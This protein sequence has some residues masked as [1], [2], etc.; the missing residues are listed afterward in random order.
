MNETGPLS[1]TS[2]AAHAR[3][4]RWGV[5]AAATLAQ[6]STCFLVQGF[7]P[8][9]PFMQDALRL[10]AFQIGLLTS[11]AQ[12]VPVIG[13]LV[14]G[15]LLDRFSERLIVGGGAL[16]VAI[17]LAAA[18]TATTF[19][20]LLAWL[21]VVGAAY[22]SAQP[23]GSKAISIWFAAAQRGVAMG[24]RQSGLPLGGALAAASLPAV[25]AAHGWP[26]AF[27]V[28]AAVAALGGILFIAVYRPPVEI[29]TRPAASAAS[30]LAARLALLG[31]RGMR[32]I[33]LSGVVLVA[34]QYG[35]LV[36]FVLDAR[37]RFGLPVATG[38]LLL[39]L[40]QMAGVVGR[41]VLAGWSDC[42]PKGRAFPI[43]MCLWALV[44]GLLVLL[45]APGAG[46]WALA[47]LAIWLGFFGLG[48]YG[49]WVAWA[50]ESAPPERVGFALG[51]VMA[52]NQIAIVTSPPLL[53][54]MRD[55]TG[56]YAVGWIMLVVLLS[57]CLGV[58]RGGRAPQTAA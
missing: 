3:A 7:G 47:I 24:V 19:P 45:M 53:G 52:I 21:L 36:F 56:G 33:M 35:V 30:A 49:P 10:N 17:A 48:W 18:S 6:A 28:G 27:R 44:A 23:G 54:A 55:W 22:S 46:A 4:Y 29:A 9:A 42:S 34:T 40:A 11:A 8:L 58:M 31:D 39:F 57:G 14:A 38:A 12:I 5:L 50:T 1:T 32:R 43:V 25:A 51:L 26:A 16:A 2:A 15:E 41:I 37:D 20:G 13:L